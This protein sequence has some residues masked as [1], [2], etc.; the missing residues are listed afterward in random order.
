MPITSLTCTSRQAR[1]HRPHWM[2]ASRLTTSQRGC[3]RAAECGLF[4]LGES[5]LSRRLRSAISHKC[6]DLSWATQRS[7]WSASSISQP[8]YARSVARLELVVTTIPSR[9]SRMQE[10][11]KRARPRLS[12]MQARQLPSGRYPAVA[13][14]TG[15]GGSVSA[16]RP[17]CERS[18]NFL[19]ASATVR[20]ACDKGDMRHMVSRASLRRSMPWY[21]VGVC[22]AEC[23]L[24]TRRFGRALGPRG[25]RC[26]SASTHGCWSQLFKQRLIPL[27]A[28]IS[29]TAFL[30]TNAAG[31]AL[32]A[33][34]I[35]ER[36]AAC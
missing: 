20:L 35:L 2:Q 25:R 14:G 9:R 29:L 18:Q 31:R 21:E 12:T 27:S 1:T 6:E 4:Q 11:T 16:D 15:C 19:T 22:A 30:A 33:A 7:G 5:G 10:A 13:C 3:R 23:P 26:R 17:I 8:S 28:C 32:A 36:T 24:I 34:F